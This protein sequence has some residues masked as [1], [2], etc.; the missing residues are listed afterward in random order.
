MFN[1]L[2]SQLSNFLRIRPEDNVAPA[3]AREFKHNVIYNTADVSFFVF[4]DAFVNLSTIMTVFTATLTDSPF[5]IGLVP[6]I[7]WASWY[8]PQIFFT[9]IVSRQRLKLPFTLKM[10]VIERIPYMLMPI[11]ALLIPHI[12]RQTA[13][14]LLLGLMVLR[15]VGG[16]FSALPWQELMATIIPISHRG[17][18]WGASRV[19]V[20]AMGV[21]GSITATVVLGRYIYP[22]NY[23]IAFSIAIVA[24]WISFFMIS[25]TREPEPENWKEPEP[26]KKILDIPM[27][28]QILK[29]DKN[30]VLYMV[31]RSISF[32]GGTATTF[33][34]VYGIR[35]FGLGDSQAAVFTGIIFFTGIIGYAYLGGLTDKIGPKRIVVFSLI[36][37][38]ASLTLTVLSPNIWVFYIVFILQGIYGA[39]LNMGDMMLVMELGEESLRPTYLGL[40]RTMTG[41]VL[42]V[43]SVSGGLIV[44]KLGFNFMF[45]L[46]TAMT[47]ASVVLFS[48]VKDRPRNIVKRVKAV[49]TVDPSSNN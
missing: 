4:A 26:N 1:R 41:V 36:C 37:L 18:F 11:L 23:A 40:A 48:M 22:Y 49:E 31:A 15:G 28:K 13:I 32:L 10:A 46:A 42:I 19:F 9:G 7:L 5:I 14:W 35:R 3:V 21:I 34:A 30:F 45:W 39:A 44:E 33:L 8:L 2:K 24:Q 29:Q 25:K 12:T 27:F 47:L 38:A 16:G 43:V 6:A 17:R 20:Q